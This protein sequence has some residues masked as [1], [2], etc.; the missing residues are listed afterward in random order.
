MSEKSDPKAEIAAMEAIAKALEGLDE[1]AVRR[2]INWTASRFDVVARSAPTLARAT[3]VEAQRP[4]A[5]DLASLYAQAAPNTEA[6]K[7]LVVSYWFQVQQG[8][9]DL[10]SA[11]V[12]VELKNLGHGIGNITQAFDKLMASRPAL[13]IQTRKSGKA[14]QARKKFRLTAAGIARVEE[15]LRASGH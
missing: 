3:S 12:N 2:V 9:E 10:E 8:H 4:G 15:M 1:D 13:A 5:A 11:A 7:A 6:E 14:Q